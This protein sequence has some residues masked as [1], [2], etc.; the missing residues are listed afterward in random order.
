MKSLLIGIFA[1]VAL[2]QL[3]VPAMMAWGRVQTLNR[4][5]VWKFKTAP[6]DPE[7]RAKLVTPLGR[8]GHAR[9]IA[10]G[11]LYL[12]SDASSY[13]TGTELVIDGGMYAGGVARR[14]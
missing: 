7:E 8:A 3:S 4:G 12:A 6:I 2:A 5:R 9:E 14:Q 1:L 11:V 10:Q 13:V